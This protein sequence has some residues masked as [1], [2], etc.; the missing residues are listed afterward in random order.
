MLVAEVFCLRLSFGL[1][2][3]EITKEVCDE[4]KL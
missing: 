1:M 4:L 3:I 2:L